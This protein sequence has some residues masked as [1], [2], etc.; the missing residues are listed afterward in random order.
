MSTITMV[1]RQKPPVNDLRML[2]RHYE[3]AT[4]T[5][6]KGRK[7]RV[8]AYI[9]AAPPAAAVHEDAAENVPSS[10]RPTSTPSFAHLATSDLALNSG[11]RSAKY[12]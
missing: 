4:P 11:G 9:L 1:S 10:Q 6:K 2:R 7:R 12:S 5:G 8:V 3:S